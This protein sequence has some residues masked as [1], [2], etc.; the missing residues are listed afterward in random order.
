MSSTLRVVRLNAGLI[1]ALSLLACSGTIPGPSS[2]PAAPIASLAIDTNV[3]WH[4]RSIVS[5]DGSVLT[6]GDPS[7]F[8]VM[9]TDDGKVSARADCNRASGGYRISGNT[10]SIGPMASTRAYCASAPVD[11]QFLMLLGGENSVTTS[12]ATLQL[13]SP[14]GTLKFGR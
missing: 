5:A 9:L 6:I 3:V 4:L 8:T 11:Q 2:V 7:L 1:A 13:S 14:R 12:D 10:V